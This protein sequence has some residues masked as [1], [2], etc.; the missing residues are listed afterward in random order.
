MCGYTRNANRATNIAVSSI[1][2]T[3]N[4]RHRTYVV[5][6]RDAPPSIRVYG[7]FMRRGYTYS[8]RT[9]A[10][11]TQRARHEAN[12]GILSTSSSSPAIAWA[13]AAYLNVFT[14]F[15]ACLPVCEC[16]CGL[17]WTFSRVLIPSFGIICVMGEWRDCGSSLCARPHSARAF[18]FDALALLMMGVLGG[19]V[20]RAAGLVCWRCVW[21]V[22]RWCLHGC[23]LPRVAFELC[24]CVCLSA[25]LWLVRWVVRARELLKTNLRALLRKC[26][27]SIMWQDVQYTRGVMGAPAGKAGSH[28]LALM[29]GRK[30]APKTNKVRVK[31]CSRWAI[32]M[33]N[34]L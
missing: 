29:F 8:S 6:P 2:R 9:S 1:P 19:D 4:S 15:C 16:V 34:G 24:V 33:R 25:F 20:Q 28:L 14:I 21:C 11:C 31:S 5:R 26:G 30:C 18:F 22:F 32:L 7:K 27:A 12:F 10:I 17:S 3:A 23:P 13:A